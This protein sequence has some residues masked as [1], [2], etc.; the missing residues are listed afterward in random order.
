M[1]RAALLLLALALAGCDTI[2][3]L[4]SARVLVPVECKEP[5]PDRPE[6]A[7]EALP[8]PATAAEVNLDAVIQAQAAEIED[9]ESYEIKLRG[10]LVRCTQPVKP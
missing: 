1:I 10:A 9:R 2:P 7:T 8:I 3:K 6:M 4:V 5:V